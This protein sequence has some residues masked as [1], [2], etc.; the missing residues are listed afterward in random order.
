VS[1]G[2]AWL[3]FAAGAL[4]AVALRAL[5]LHPL[6]LPSSDPERAAVAP[7]RGAAAPIVLW[8]DA[9][10]LDPDPAPLRASARDWGLAWSNLLD[11]EFGAHRIEPL[12][13]TASTTAGVIV[14]T[15]GAARAAANPQALAGALADLASS[16]RTIVIEL[17]P[18]GPLADLAGLAVPA[19]AQ[20][21]PSSDALAPGPDAPAWLPA[22]LGTLPAPT[23]ALAAR[24]GG[25][26]VRVLL[27]RGA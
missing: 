21:G 5:D 17:P 2:R 19:E 26:G 24:T 25:E 27:R 16:G 22:E 13:E 12:P 1:R 18:P 10:L 15:A 23:V 11:Q 3:A 20:L 7:D 9:A 4:L 14:L 8:V 6:V